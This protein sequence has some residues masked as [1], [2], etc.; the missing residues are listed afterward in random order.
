MDILV[1]PSRTF[2]NWSEQFGRVLVEA[3][4]CGVCVVGSDAGE[5]PHV[6]GDAGLIFPED[7]LERLRKHLQDLIDNAEGRQVFGDKGRRRVMERYT[8]SHIAQA[9][10][11]VYRDLVP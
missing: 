1:L 3:M 5:I 11:K 7:N 6:I 2:P 8:Q 4:A 9:T 10:L